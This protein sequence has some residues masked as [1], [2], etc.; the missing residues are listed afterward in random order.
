MDNSSCPKFEYCSAPICPLDKQV[1]TR[2]HL[3][4]ETTCLYLREYA[5]TGFRAIS[6]GYIP[7]NIGS[8]ITLVYPA[9]IDR[10]VPLKKQLMRATLSGS[11]REQFRCVS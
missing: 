11:K 6:E 5:K 4:G 1:L 9:L 2:S 10:Y 8:A 7:R 3:K